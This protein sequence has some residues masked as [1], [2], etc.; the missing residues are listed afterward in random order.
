M[1]IGNNKSPI[2]T[3]NGQNKNYDPGNVS[4]ALETVIKLFRNRNHK[5]KYFKVRAEVWMTVWETKN[6]ANITC[7]S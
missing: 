4:K 5:K 2:K 6:N 1:N 7:I 3:N